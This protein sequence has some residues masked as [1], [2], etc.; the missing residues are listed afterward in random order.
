MI[1]S[2]KLFIFIRKS[3]SAAKRIFVPMQYRLPAFIIFFFLLP[4]SGY[5]QQT[6][7]VASYNS[8]TDILL[9]PDTIPP[10]AGNRR[11]PWVAGISAGAVGGSLLLLNQAWYKSQSRTSFHF[12][13]DNRE[14]LQ[15]DKWGHT[16]SAYNAARATSSMWHWAGLSRKKAAVLG[17]ITSYSYLTGIELLDGFAEK[18]GW[19]WGDVAA[20]TTGIGLY[21]AQ[22]LAWQEQRIQYKFS[23]HANRYP[24]PILSERANDLFGENFAEKM[25]KDYNAQTYWFSANIHSFFPNSKWPPWLN[26]AIGYGASGMYGGFENRWETASGNLVDRRD[27][28]RVRQFYFAPDIDFTRIRTKSRFLKTTFSILNAFK[29]PAPTFMIDGKGRARVYAVYF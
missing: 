23:F 27:I 15:V 22:E 28:P 20:N 10:P 7:T 18:W 24:N 5:A 13:N 8:G 14:W 21:L 4:F 2:L 17:A 9:L 19:S 6:D 1:K 16:W 11:L 29:F 26:L 12:F 25:L 3:S